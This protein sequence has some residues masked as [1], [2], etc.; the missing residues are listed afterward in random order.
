MANTNRTTT[1]TVSTNATSASLQRLVAER[2]LLRLES[3]FLERVLRGLG[4]RKV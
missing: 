4:R 1:K 2:D 3:A